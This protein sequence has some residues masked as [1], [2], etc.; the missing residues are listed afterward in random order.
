MMD[1]DDDRREEQKTGK[2]QILDSRKTDQEKDMAEKDKGTG[3]APCHDGN[4]NPAVE[5]Q[6]PGYIEQGEQTHTGSGKRGQC[7]AH[8]SGP[9]GAAFLR[10]VIRKFPRIRS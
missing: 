6:R 8:F 5:I 7:A 4:Q 2:N 9:S 3:Q 1:A 10:M